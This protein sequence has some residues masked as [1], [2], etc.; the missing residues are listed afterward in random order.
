MHNKQDGMYKTGTLILRSISQ[1]MCIKVQKLPCNI[2]VISRLAT[3]IPLGRWLDGPFLSQLA[4]F[5]AGQLPV[6]EMGSLL[7]SNLQS[8][9][10]FKVSQTVSKQA[11]FETGPLDNRLPLKLDHFKMGS[12]FVSVIHVYTCKL[13]DAC[14][15]VSILLHLLLPATLSQDG[16]TC[17]RLRLTP[18]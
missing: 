6:F 11:R 7:W 12:S 2:H 3:S 17:Y 5:K 16:Q 14:A 10:Y 13:L 1:G 18:R 8:P 15:G 9:P 4:H